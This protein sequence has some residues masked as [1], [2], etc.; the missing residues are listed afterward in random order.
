MLVHIVAFTDKVNNYFLLFG[1][2][3]KNCTVFD[4]IRWNRG[5]TLMGATDPNS[6]KLSEFR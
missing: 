1:T 6:L 2:G 3:T 4:K 5:R